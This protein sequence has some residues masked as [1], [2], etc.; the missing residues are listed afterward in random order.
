MDKMISYHTHTQR[1][2]QK[3]LLY[4]IMIDE[5]DAKYDRIDKHFATSNFHIIAAPIIY[6]HTIKPI[7]I[8]IVII[9]NWFV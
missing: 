8:N 3:V 4:F 2:V 5:I 6:T 7:N 1:L 9:I